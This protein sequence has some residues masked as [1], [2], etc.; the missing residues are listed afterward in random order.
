[1]NN[2]V[3]QSTILF[4][5][6]VLAFGV[7]FIIETHTPQATASAF[8]GGQ[9]NVATSTA[10]SAPASAIVVAATSSCAARVI[11]TEGSAIML[12]F[13]DLVG[14]SPTG[15]VGHWQAA[16]TTVAYDG[17]QYGCGLVKAFSYTAQTLTVTETR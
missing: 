12:T 7:A 13:S 2:L 8:P 14:G 16:S 1:M 10:Y 5:G 4:L 9:A 15:S 11:T 17:G 3:Y 6:L